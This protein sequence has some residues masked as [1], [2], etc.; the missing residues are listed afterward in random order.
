MQNSQDSTPFIAAGS[1]L[2]IISKACQNYT[3]RLVSEDFISFL[4]EHIFCDLGK[5][6]V[7]IY[8]RDDSQDSFLPYPLQPSSFSLKFT[9]GVP[10]LIPISEPLLTDL[11]THHTC[12]LF[13]NGP[14]VP[15]FLPATGNQSHA[16]FPIPQGNETVALLYIGCQ[17]NLLF[18]DEYLLGVQTVTLLIGSWM[19]S[20]D[21]ISDLKRSMTSLANSERL[22]QAL[23]EISEQS[24]LAATEED[25]FSS[26][27]EIVGRFVNARNFFIALREERQGE[28]YVKYAYYF[29]ELDSYLQGMEFKIDPKTQLSMAGFIIQSGE[30]LILKPD[31]FDRICLENDIKPL[32]SKAYSLVGVPFYYDNLAGVVLVQ[33][34]NEIIYTE[35][36]KDLLI[37]VARQIGD[38]LGRKKTIDEMRNVNEM[39]SLFMHYSPVHVYIKE[40]T[41]SQGLILQVSEAYSKSLGLSESEIIGK[42]MTE[43][44]SADF[45]AK[46]IADDW[47]V[48]SNGVPLQLEEHLADRTYT[49]IKFPI[50]QKSKTL[51]AGFTI[52]ITDQKAMEEALRESERRYR[53][54]FEKSP[55]AIISFDSVGTILDFNDKF[56]EIMGASREKLLGFQPAFS[57]YCDSAGSPEKIFSRQGRLLRRGLYLKNRREVSLSTRDIQSPYSW[58]ITH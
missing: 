45:A 5:V 28:H 3:E 13:N 53:I 48:I 50:P 24:H 14:A 25:L 54:I 56:M 33:S 15:A 4:R 22:R 38:A 34:Y 57:E 8:F 36:D 11:F 42:S 58:S 17:E 26:L 1:F 35:K 41:E 30:P 20:L 32:G 6:F 37:Y 18:P 29:D 31:N 16:F 10:K 7:E 23:Y 55:L 12:R 2:R 49:T 44:F 40:V 9:V 19:K 51:L 47:N 46:T 43:L 52:D 27:H 39:F 21:I